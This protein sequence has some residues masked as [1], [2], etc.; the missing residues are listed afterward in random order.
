[1]LFTYI[2]LLQLQR[3]LYRLPPG[4]DR[5]QTYLR[6]M[7]DAYSGDLALPLTVMN[8]M[9]K[10]HVPAFLDW[11][12]ELDADG[13]AASATAAAVTR[14]TSEVGNYR[15]ALVVCDD[16]RGG[17]TNRYTTDFD[18]RFRQKPYYQRGWLP[19]ILWAS[20]NY[21]AE[22]IGEE[23]GLAIFRLAYIQRHGYAQ[24]LQECLTQESYAM[25][26]VGATSPTLTAEDLDYTRQVLADCWDNSS[27]S[28]LLTALYGDP[29]AHQLGYSPLGLSPNA[30][31][32]LATAT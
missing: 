29:A 32:A 25:Q 14:L 24:S 5:F 11:L 4:P 20:E 10:E 17:W 18:Y 12:L 27:T 30:G 8:P 23:I 15:V 13:I 22:R 9:A 21:S 31:L 19:T 1:M 2:P 3:D 16:L 28:F 26:Q 7:T 6:T